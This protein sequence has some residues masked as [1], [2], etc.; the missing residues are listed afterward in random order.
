MVI[1]AYMSVLPDAILPE[2]ST[3]SDGEFK[4]IFPFIYPLVILIHSSLSIDF[5]GAVLL[6]LGTTHGLVSQHGKVKKWIAPYLTH[7]STM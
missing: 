7:L 5:S 2:P 3:I 1:E 4:E 6:A